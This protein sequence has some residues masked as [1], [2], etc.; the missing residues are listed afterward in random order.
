MGRYQVYLPPPT[1]CLTFGPSPEAHLS[2]STCGREPRPIG[3]GRL[4]PEEAAGLGPPTPAPARGL[5]PGHTGQRNPL[6]HQ[7]DP[8][9][10]RQGPTWSPGPGSGIMQPRVQAFS[11][12]DQSF[13]CM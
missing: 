7:A 3:P 6:P 5:L 12:K 4:I 9:A 13:H 11:L 1:S 2:P 10:L 8:V